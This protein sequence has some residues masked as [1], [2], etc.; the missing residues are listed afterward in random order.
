ME[1]VEEQ[2]V[3]RIR[4]HSLRRGVSGHVLFH[5]EREPVRERFEN[6]ENVC[7]FG[8]IA[9]AEKYGTTR[10]KHQVV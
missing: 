2:D 5:H 4:Y 7:E 8:G 9:T 6:S 3:V 1:L 10:R